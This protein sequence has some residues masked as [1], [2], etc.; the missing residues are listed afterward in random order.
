MSCLL[1]LS[2]MDETKRLV[3]GGAWDGN[4]LVASH[5]AIS[6][7][8]LAGSNGGGSTKAPPLLTV[9]SNG[10]SSNAEVRAVCM[11]GTCRQC[12][13]D[14]ECRKSHDEQIAHSFF[15]SAKTTSILYST[16]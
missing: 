6:S 9:E 2:V 8:I 12:D 11:D 13:G 3:A 7:G 10:A 4:G 1:W 15:C 14:D 16:T 5:G